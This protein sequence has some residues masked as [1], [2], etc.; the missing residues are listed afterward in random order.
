MSCCG[1]APLVAQEGDR[2]RWTIYVG[3]FNADTDTELRTSDPEV[4][5]GPL[6]SLE[7]DLGVDDSATALRF[8][9]SRNFGKSRR[10]LLEFQYLQIDRDGRALIED[11][12]EYGGDV[13]PVG[14]DV[15]TDVRTEDFDLHYTYLLVDNEKGRFGISAGLHGIRIESNVSGTYNI[16]GGEFPA[17]VFQEERLDE[18]FPLPLVGIRGSYF[19]SS[20]WNLLAAI[21]FL[22][23]EVGDIEGGFVDA[24]AQLEYELSDTVAL[25]LGYA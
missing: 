8:R 24:W 10:H 14:A 15:S 18:E 23:V 7:D 16:G 11:E 13:Y 3:G 5:D 17:D 9:I 12:L 19:L 21:K 1:A 2:K 4:G 20:K 6:V 25:G 22:D